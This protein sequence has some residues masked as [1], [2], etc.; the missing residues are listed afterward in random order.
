MNID[1]KEWIE[2]KVGDVSWYGESN[3][4][5]QSF[6]NMSVL[7]EYLL[8]LEDIYIRL[9]YELTDHKI[10]REGNASAIYL[11]RKA[12]EILERRKYVFDDLKDVMNDLDNWDSEDE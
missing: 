12:K 11:H 5:N 6:D 3:H 10:Y 2:Y 9:L 4:D 7:E 1:L 8:Q